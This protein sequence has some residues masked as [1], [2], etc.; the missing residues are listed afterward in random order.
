M[1]VRYSAHIIVLSLC[2]PLVAGSVER[3]GGD[4]WR[5][6]GQLPLAAEGEV[7]WHSIAAIWDNRSV[8]LLELEIAS[9]QG[10]QSLRDLRSEHYQRGK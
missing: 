1:I 9:R 8:D 10:L 4:D 3:P 5:D 7:T 6:T 2:R